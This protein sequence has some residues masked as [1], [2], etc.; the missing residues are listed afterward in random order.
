MK[1]QQMVSCRYYTCRI[2]FVLSVLLFSISGA[3]ASQSL[4]QIGTADNDTGEL[5]HGPKSYQDYRRGGVFI[6]GQSDPKRDWPYVQPGVVDGGWAPGGPQVFEVYFGL[7]TVPSG[8]YQLLLDF[9]DTHSITPPKI[10]V[11]VNDKSWEFQT[12][13]GSGDA[14][15][16]GE[17]AKGREHLIEISVPANALRQGNNRVTI[18]TLNGS[19]ILWDA[20]S[21]A[22]PEKTELQ[23]VEPETVIHSVGVKPVLV[24]HENK[25]ARPIAIDI[26]HVGE[27]EDVQIRAGKL[28]TTHRLTQGLQTVVV[29]VPEAA[30][31]KTLKIE[32]SVNKKT[33]AFESV[34][35]K[36]VRKWEIHL[37]HQTH[38]DIG[39]THRQEEVL[40]LQVDHLYKALEYIDKSK[41]YPE[42][43]QFKW[44]PEGMWAVDE[45]MRRAS[46]KDKTRLVDAARK[47]LIHIDSMYA[48]AMT[49]VYSEEELFELMGSAK[50][51][52]DKYG[53]VLNSATQS[54][55]P[56]YTWGLVSALAHHGVKYISVGPNP[57][58]RLGSLYDLADDPF[59]W[60]S[61]SGKEKVLFLLCG[62]GY[63][64]F[65]GK[66]K[67]HRIELDA[68]GSG[69][70]AGS[71]SVY[72][73]ELEKKQYPYDMVMLRY[74][75]ERDNGS[76]NPV[77]SDVV[78]EWNEKY[79]YPK[80][81]ISRNGE[82]FE[83]FEKRY[84]DQI[85]VRS[86]DIT[87][88]WEDGVAS[89]AAD[90]AM[91]KRACEHIVQ[92]QVLWSMLKPQDKLHG[93][94]DAAWEKMI[95]YDEHTWGA[96]NSISEPDSAFA[97]QQAEYK[98]R[99]ALDGAK[100]A[101]ELLSDI[102]G[103]HGQN[104]SNYVDVY[105]TASWERSE[106][107]LLSAKQSAAGDQI[108]DE[109]GKVV[110]SQR[111]GSG[112]LAFVAAE[113]PAF[114]GRRYAV[115][116][117]KARV[118]GTVKV[119]GVNLSND[120][121][122]ITIDRKTGAIKSLVYKDN[123]KELVDGSRDSG[124]NDYLYI[125]GRDDSK[126]HVRVSGEVKVTVEDSGPLV[127]TVRIESGAPGC[128]KL[129]RIVRIVSGSERVELTNITD[130]LKE[131]RPEGVYFEYPFNIPGGVSKIDIPWATCEPEKDQMEKGANRNYYCVQRW[132]DISNDDYGVIWVTVDAPML[133]FH[134]IKIASGFNAKDWRSKIEPGQTFYSW[135]MNNHWETNYKA[136]QEGVITFKYVI[137]PHD[138]GYDSV[139]SQ[140]IGRSV[141][142]GLIVTAADPAKPVIQPMLKVNGDGV[143]VTSIRPSRN[144]KGIM[145]RL[146]N[147]SGQQQNTSLKW[148]VEPEGMWLSNPM[149][150]KLS[151]LT[152]PIQMVPHEIVTLRIEML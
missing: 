59:Y 88:Y 42:E 69:F 152:G 142:Q 68:E 138:G 38:L 24:W 87:P 33:L 53:V 141:C 32:L 125:L 126:G 57:G 93:R 63:A 49:G 5:A 11:G 80:L 58:H 19:W 48:Q 10:S 79:A 50:L 143:V 30:K 6:V 52:C 60:V 77:L 71:I 18:T 29:Y 75:I 134:P 111:L 151:S 144:G 128:S 129:T 108:R 72:L 107:V 64:K 46:D 120:R 13:K 103:E 96:W 118:E 20:L 54:D 26:L 124:I 109:Q 113:V 132:V 91:N 37:I 78:K 112:E 90:T 73:S 1:G 14:S 101:E 122:A 131:R 133:Q 137:A 15:V 70:H 43:A 67:G 21:F 147:I 86:G 2:L 117:G 36:P 28:Q 130:K 12:P 35:L 66:P 40:D 146:F 150:E 97:M 145:V 3:D 25:K 51:F 47:R 56:G 115:S 83:L 65:H 23:D 82:F 31:A 135:V 16:F 102:T 76:P 84:S 110:P 39:Y 7:K 89:T 85:P 127:G 105:N 27:E 8:S 140:K 99:F 45:F 94:F 104:A 34:E 92:A 55:V 116:K 74:C 119:A 17:P 121:V 61:P 139:K 95:M 81:I 41:D 44:H 106:L 100:M 62:G 148:S 9:V 4:W 123:G 114:G 136:D 98:S 22:G 149:E